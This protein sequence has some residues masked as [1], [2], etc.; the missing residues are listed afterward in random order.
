[1]ARVVREEVV[2]DGPG[3]GA[4]WGFNPIPA[5]VSV[6][7]VVLLVVLLWGPISRAVDDG[8]KKGGVNVTVDHNNGNNK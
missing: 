5:L 4:G 2:D 7:A 1:M 6:L 3:G 8:N